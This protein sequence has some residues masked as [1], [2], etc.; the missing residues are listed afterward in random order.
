MFGCSSWRMIWTSFKIF[1]LC[2]WCQHD[3][4]TCMRCC[5]CL[6]RLATTTVEGPQHTREGGR[7]RRRA[8]HRTVLSI[9]VRQAE[10][11]RKKKV[12]KSFSHLCGFWSLWF[13]VRMKVF[14]SLRSLRVGQRNKIS[15]E[16]RH[17]NSRKGDRGNGRSCEPPT[18]G[19][20]LPAC[21]SSR[22]C[23]RP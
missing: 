12:E 21:C 8:R 7:R 16:S 4:G 17:I 22:I 18:R 6:F 5:R 10:S 13:E 9:I 20:I 19:V 15:R 23:G 11:Q 2:G 1:A 14:V 3:H